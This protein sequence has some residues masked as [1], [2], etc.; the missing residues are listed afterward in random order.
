[1][2]C[3]KHGCND[4]VSDDH[5][6]SD[7]L[8]GLLHKVLK[9]H[10][11]DGLSQM[12]LH[13]IGHDTG[14]GLKKA[15]YLVDNPDFNHLLGA[16]GYDSC[17]CG[18]HKKDLWTDPHSFKMDMQKAEYHNSVRRFLHD[19]LHKREINLN[20]PSEVKDL[21]KHIGIEQPKFFSWNMKHGN[22]GLLIFEKPEKDLGAWKEGLLANVAAL[23]S[24]CSI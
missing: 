1:M 13:E 10:D 19:S 24:F 7:Y 22:H 15:T 6:L 4:F 17:E 11:V 8:S 18:Y 20:D 23:L 12:V 5:R 9:Y 21:G 3:N 14:F 16:A 2:K